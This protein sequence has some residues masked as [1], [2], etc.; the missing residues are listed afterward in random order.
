MAAAFVAGDLDGDGFDD[1]VT[2]GLEHADPE[3]VPCDDGCPAFER[4]RL[5]VFYGS[6]TFGAEGGLEP[7]AQLVGVYVNTPR[8]SAWPAGDVDGDG[9]DELLVSV[10]TG[11]CEQGDSFLVPG[12]PRL[13]GT[14]DVRDVGGLI[15]ESEADCTQLG[16]AH[17]VGDLDGDGLDD[18]AVATP[19]DGHAHLF[20]GA[21]DAPTGPR[22]SEDDAHASFIAEGVDDFGVA[23]PAGDVDGDGF[24]DLLLSAAPRIGDWWIRPS[25]PREHWLVRGGPE[26]FAGGLDVRGLGTR[27][28]ARGVVAVGDLDGDGRD[29]LAILDAPGSGSRLLAGR[30]EWP[31]A[32]DPSAFGPRL[33]AFGGEGVANAAAAGDVNGDGHA[34]L[35]IGEPELV[36]EGSPVGAVQLHLGPLD[37]SAETLDPDTA[38]LFLGQRWIAPGADPHPGRI[39][40][41]DRLGEVLVPGGDLNGDG[42]DDQVFTA[43][44]AGGE[45]INDGRLYVW[46]GR[47]AS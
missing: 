32:L 11:N 7:S 22:R 29:D 34:D 14:R 40:G 44:N 3:V 41:Y 6:P 8:L 1:L 24:D 43:R 10:G 38:T 36:S 31:P 35:L 26:R 17:G 15:R 45:E 33:E 27:I 2:W 9:D 21:P 13:S 25:S 20:Y 42:R 5:Y 28:V 30:S 16:E 47:G 39:R 23:A 46:L 19:G 37:P 12:G 4:I 18:Y